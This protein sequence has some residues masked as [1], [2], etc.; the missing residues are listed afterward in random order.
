MAN[1]LRQPAQNSL[2][3]QSIVLGLIPRPFNANNC[4]RHRQDSSLEEGGGRG[5]LSHCM[6]CDEGK[7]SISMLCFAKFHRQAAARLQGTSFCCEVD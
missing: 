5:I 2:L 3:W 1:T 7:H 4:R 6:L